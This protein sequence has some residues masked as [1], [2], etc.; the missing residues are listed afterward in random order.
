MAN[1]TAKNVMKFEESA[2]RIIRAAKVLMDDDMDARI[3]DTLV[4]SVRHYVVS[5]SEDT[6]NDADMDLWITT[7][8]KELFKP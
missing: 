6:T 5:T 8:L 3:L 7:T 4:C 2:N 1:Q